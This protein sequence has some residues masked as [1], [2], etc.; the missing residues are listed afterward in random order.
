ME[1]NRRFFLAIAA[2]AGMDPE[3]LLWVPGRKLIS[4]AAPL[5]VVP[6]ET[7]FGMPALMPYVPMSE[8]VR[9]LLA[10][11]PAAR[12]TAEGSGTVRFTEEVGG[13]VAGVRRKG[14]PW[15][16][17][18]PVIVPATRLPMGAYKIG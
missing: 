10:I 17:R 14:N 1:M 7:L 11:D 16:E 2:T 6:I 5:D 13:Y 15:N 4:I 8:R 12:F 18:S 9:A 3:R